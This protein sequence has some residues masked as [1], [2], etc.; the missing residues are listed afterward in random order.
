LIERIKSSS[1]SH[2]QKAVEHV[3]IK[4]PRR[5]LNSRDNKIYAEPIRKSKSKSLKRTE[6]S[7]SRDTL[8][9]INKDRKP[10]STELGKNISRNG[11]GYKIGCYSSRKGCLNS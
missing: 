4:K 6:R 9:E 5:T 2:S 11:R 7:M 10:E 1:K 3:E 8:K